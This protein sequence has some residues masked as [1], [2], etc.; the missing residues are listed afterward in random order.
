MA[1]IKNWKR[2]KKKERSKLT[3][4]AWRNTETGDLVTVDQVKKGWEALYSEIGGNLAQRQ[5]GKV[6]DKDSTQSCARSAAVTWMRN[7][8]TGVQGSEKLTDIGRQKIE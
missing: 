8:P 2:D 5:G 4:Y 7:H 3:A 1:R 6:I